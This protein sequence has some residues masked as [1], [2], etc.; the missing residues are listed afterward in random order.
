M[1]GLF[2][3]GHSVTVP[4]RP[5]GTVGDRDD[6][7]SRRRPRAGLGN[8]EYESES[9]RESDGRLQ[10]PRAGPWDAVG[11]RAD[12]ELAL[13]DSLRAPTR[14]Q[15]WSQRQPEALPSCKLLTESTLTLLCTGKCSASESSNFKY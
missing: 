11:R 9:A 14:S 15:I 12:L 1:I 10:T 4:G 8:C 3:K 13:I 6:S 2:S 5:S 7:E